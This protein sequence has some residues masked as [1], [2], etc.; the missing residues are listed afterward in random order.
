MSWDEISGHQPQIELLRGSIRRHRLS[1]T[2]LFVGTDGIGKRTF[3]LQAAQ[4][5]L[6]KTHSENEFLACGHCPGCKQ[7]LAGTHPDLFVVGCPEGKREIPIDTFLGPA[8]RRGKSGLCY[9]LSHTP[10]AGGRKIAIIA[11]AEKLN[12]ESANALLKT[13]EEPPPHSLIILIA[14]NTDSVLPTIRSR[15]QIIRFNAL[16]TQLVT[17]LL[18]KNGSTSDHQAAAQAA[19]SCDGSL[20]QAVMLLDPELRAKRD[21]LFDLLAAGPF[22]S[23][24]VTRYVMEGVEATGTEAPL[25]REQALWFFRFSIDF[26]RTAMREMIQPESR[27]IPQAAQ[28]RQRIKNPTA[29]HLTTLIQVIERVISGANH[30]EQN[31]AVNLVVESLFDEVG[32]ILRT[33]PA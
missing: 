12:D 2:Y 8:E 20:S 22:N 15:C 33:L 27:L 7:V 11:D 24:A 5:L 9:D 4:C 31:V 23:I 6:C 25:Q 10:M 21:R 29:D 28:F 1:H 30:I 13:L 19:G 17:N 18:L 14:T 26:F 16:S 32:R 3:A